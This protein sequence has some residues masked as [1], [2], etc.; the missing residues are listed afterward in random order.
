MTLNGYLRSL[1]I[2]AYKEYSANERFIVYWINFLLVM[3]S[4]D[5]VVTILYYC[6]HFAPF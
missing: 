5:F 6:R 2:T 4:K 1:K 3:R